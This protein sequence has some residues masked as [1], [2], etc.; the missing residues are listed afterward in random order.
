[1][2]L[3]MLP[4]KTK[5]RLPI[6]QLLMVTKVSVYTSNDS[7]GKVKSNA[8]CLIKVEVEDNKIKLLYDAYQ[9]HCLYWRAHGRLALALR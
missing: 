7:S 9:S 2:S 5:S 1:M 4:N 3:N 8:E 6:V